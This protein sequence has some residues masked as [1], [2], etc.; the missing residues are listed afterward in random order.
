MYQYE[1]LITDVAS[2]GL[3]N[4]R[5]ALKRFVRGPAK[6]NKAKAARLLGITRP[7]VHAYLAERRPRAD[8]LARLSETM[9]RSAMEDPASPAPE[10]VKQGETDAGT[11]ALAIQ[12]VRYLYELL[13]DA[14]A[15]SRR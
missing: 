5:D 4:F 11:P 14:D 8:K 6:G 12:L 7:E 15:R 10:P 9:R 3:D 1:R 13:E 2:I